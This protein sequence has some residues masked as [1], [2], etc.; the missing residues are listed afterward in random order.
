MNYINGAYLINDRDRHILF[1][2]MKLSKDKLLD[3][4]PLTP[5][6][7]SSDSEYLTAVF[8]DGCDYIGH[9]NLQGIKSVLNTHLNINILENNFNKCKNVFPKLLF[10]EFN[11]L[12]KFSNEQIKH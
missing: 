10:D 5:D 7:E 2:Y 1:I 12:Q 3:A 11:Q 4:L 6:L 9:T 8:Q